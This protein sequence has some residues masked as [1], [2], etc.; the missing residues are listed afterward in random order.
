MRS[1]LARCKPSSSLAANTIERCLLPRLD[2]LYQTRTL[3]RWYRDQTGPPSTPE[4]RLPSFRKPDSPG[5]RSQEDRRPRDFE[6]RGRTA[7]QRSTPRY[8]RDVPIPGSSSDSAGSLSGADRLFGS[9]TVP[10]GGFRRK[11]DTPLDPRNRD[12]RNLDFV[13]FESDRNQLEPVASGSTL[14]ESER[15]VFEQLR[16]LDDNA[17]K[18]KQEDTDA[19]KP[20]PV[21]RVERKTA[22]SSLDA[23]LDAAMADTPVDSDNDTDPEQKGESTTGGSE[24]LTAINDLAESQNKSP[25]AVQTRQLERTRIISQIDKCKTDHAIWEVFE[26]SILAPV[27]SLGLDTVEQSTRGATSRRG[28][29][30]SSGSAESQLEIIGPNLAPSLVH[31]AT[32]LRTKFPT[33]P[34]LLALIPRLRQTGPSAFALGATTSLYNECL[35]QLVER[36][37]DFLAVADMIAEM[38]RE[39]IPS[40]KKTTDLLSSLL[41]E[42][43]YMRSGRY[44]EAAKSYIATDRVKKAINE[45]VDTLVQWRREVRFAARTAK[46]TQEAL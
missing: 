22:A 21:Q 11:P 27:A 1:Q 31:T 39:V 36:N 24:E 6:R 34:L 9:A 38:E 37:G 28:R 17:N 29:R 23:I 40:D 35:A 18:P 32:T 33:S 13:P 4:R 45:V 2:F 12:T 26:R 43:D 8:R 41:E 19:P 42:A 16:S 44:G 7:D 5:F 46:G 30:S 20:P 14:T 3:Q 15:R 25:P 10:K